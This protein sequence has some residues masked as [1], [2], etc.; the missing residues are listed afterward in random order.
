MKQLITAVVLSLM[1]SI[2]FAGVKAGQKAPD[3]TL[4]D[5]HGKTHSLSDFKGKYTVIEWTNYDCPFV[6]KHYKEGHMQKLQKEL[7]AKNIVWLSVNS[8][9]KGKQGQFSDH[10]ANNRM[11]KMNAKPT[12]YLQDI[13][14][15]VGKLY[16]A[17]STPQMFVLDKNHKVVY[18]GAIDSIRSAKTKDISKATN[19]V[20]QAL[21][22]VMNGQKVSVDF[23]PSYGCSVKY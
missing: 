20:K 2:S 10:E 19:Y 23:T 16:S 3:F 21:N 18:A 14:G 5:T 9:A 8:S 4:T 7:T 11:E 15:K 13:S 1:A 12:A 22:E 17:K 6:K